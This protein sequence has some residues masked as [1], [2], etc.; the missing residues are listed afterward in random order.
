MSYSVLDQAYIITVYFLTSPV[1]GMR[2][3]FAPASHLNQNEQKKFSGFF[4]VF[5]KQKIGGQKVIYIWNILSC[6]AY[7]WQYH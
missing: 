5:Y 1:V 2:G 4:L 3:I 6:W 7:D